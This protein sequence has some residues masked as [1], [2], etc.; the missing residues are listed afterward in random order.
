MGEVNNHSSHKKIIAYAGIDP[1]VHQS[2]KLIGMSKLSKSGNRH[3]RRA[4][5]LMTASVVSQNT[6]F[7]PYFLKR[8]K[9]GRIG[10]SKS[11]ICH[12]AQTDPG[13]LSHE[14]IS[15]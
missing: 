11:H 7:K 14:H 12:S 6:Y 2:G 4:I 9:E 15:T 13:L 5:Y 3:L 8:K 1:S 10:S